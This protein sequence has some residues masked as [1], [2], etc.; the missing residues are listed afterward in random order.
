MVTAAIE[1]ASLYTGE[2]LNIGSYAL[3][4]HMLA[5]RSGLEIGAFVW[6]AGDRHLYLDHLDRARALGPLPRI[7]IVRPP[8]TID[9]YALEAIVLHG[10]EAQSHLK[11]PVAI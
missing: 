10:Y 2:P 3:P 9:G 4:T 1:A 5:Q 8:D 7:A 11:T 6:T